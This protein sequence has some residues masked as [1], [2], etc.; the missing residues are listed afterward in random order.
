MVVTGP[1]LTTDVATPVMRVCFVCL[2]NICRSPT[3]AAIMAQLV[4]D[5]GLELEVHVESAGTGGWHVGDGADRRA[6]AEA[7]RRGIPM[8]HAAQQFTARDF[9]RFDLV[10]AMDR[11]NHDDLRSI[12]PDEHAAGKIRLLR[13][14]DPTAPPEAVV[15]DPYYGGPQ[16]FADV[17]DMVERACRGL[18]ATLRP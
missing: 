5:A 8:P 15:P 3:A 9:A 12:A 4:R 14:Y 17:F 7:R 13:A 10:L 18:L 16:G 11:D 1:G 2:G 6:V